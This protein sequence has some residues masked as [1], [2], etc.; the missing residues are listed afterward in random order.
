MAKRGQR[1]GTASDIRAI[2][3]SL[4]NI[5]E[6][7]VGALARVGEA[8]AAAAGPRLHAASTRP[9]RRKVRLSAGRLT[10]LQLQGRYMALVRTLKPR[11]KVQVRALRATKGV[12][13]AIALAARLAKA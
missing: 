7:L 2:R 8:S 4:V 9:R 10:A 1:D 11:Q 3:N 13:A 5:V 12:G 6:S